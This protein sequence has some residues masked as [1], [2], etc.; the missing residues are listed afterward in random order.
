MAIKEISFTK[1]EL[2]EFEKTIS[3]LALRYFG[4]DAH[5]YRGTRNLLHLCERYAD[6]RLGLL[7][8][9]KPKSDLKRGQV[10]RKIKA[11]IRSLQKED[12]RDLP[13]LFKEEVFR[14]YSLALAGEL[15]GKCAKE[16]ARDFKPDEFKPEGK[17]GHEFR[18]YLEAILS[19]H[20]IE[21][22]EVLTRTY[23]G[24]LR[25]LLATLRA[26]EQ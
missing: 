9:E 11:F 16:F 20:Q 8:T 3:S 4:G 14:A 21:L 17:D 22:G 25:E 1:E 13:Q 2:E 26:L 12:K 5:V 24:S 10:R 15:G 6:R 23:E 18:L 19:P 7:P